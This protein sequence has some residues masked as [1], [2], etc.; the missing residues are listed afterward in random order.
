MFLFY[1]VPVSWSLGET[2]TVWDVWV[3]EGGGGP[4]R[5]RA[6]EVLLTDAGIHAN[7]HRSNN[8]LMCRM[9]LLCVVSQQSSDLF[10]QFK[11]EMSFV[12]FLSNETSEGQFSVILIICWFDC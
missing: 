3:G 8:R 9:C 5:I 10:I 11:L 6:E 12:F 7:T 4:E 1:S 2:I